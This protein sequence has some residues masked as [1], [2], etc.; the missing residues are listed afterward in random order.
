L[1]SGELLG[2]VVDIEDLVAA[3]EEGGDERRVAQQPL[4]GLLGQGPALTAQDQVFEVVVV[5]QPGQGSQVDVDVGD[6]PGA[7]PDP[8]TDAPAPV[9]LGSPEAPAQHD[10]RIDPLVGGLGGQVERFVEVIAGMGAVEGVL[11]PG[12]L[13]LGVEVGAGLVVAGE[14]EVGEVVEGIRASFGQ[15][16]LVR[17]AGGVRVRRSGQ[18]LR[19]DGGRQEVDR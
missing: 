8:A 16:S 14:R 17:C 6:D 13:V 18:R 1:S 3:G 11:R 7:G 10:Q 9:L 12:L 2:G 15:G 5:S 4:G 19:A